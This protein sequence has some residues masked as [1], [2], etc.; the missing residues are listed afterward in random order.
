MS[1]STSKVA[2]F[3]ITAIP[4]FGISIGAWRYFHSG[5]AG[6]MALGITTLIM[7]RW[8]HE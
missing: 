7:V 3:I 1:M 6:I 8:Q 5:W 2:D 4:V